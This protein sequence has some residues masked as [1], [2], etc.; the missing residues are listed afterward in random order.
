M[1][2]DGHVLRALTALLLLQHSRRDTRN[3]DQGRIVVLPDQDRSRWH[4][5]EI[6]SAVERLR[7]TPPT[8]GY[9][10]ELRLH[11]V[12]AA[13]H[14]L[15]PGF[16]DTDWHT[17][18]ATYLR[19][20]QQTGSPLVRLNRAIALAELSGPT[21]GLVLLAGLEERLPQQHRVAVARAELLR[22]AGHV[23]AARTAYRDAISYCPP[24]AEAR[25]LRLRLDSL[26]SGYPGVA[27][28][29]PSTPSS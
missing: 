24:G 15:A 4:A 12:I 1:P 29:P 2:D 27:R 6:A 14:A 3:D 20:E 28:P 19:L 26:D 9:V 8:T 18:S 11:A 5:E 16:G 10:E 21:A 7:R 23:E 13:C 22:R 25:H 17:I